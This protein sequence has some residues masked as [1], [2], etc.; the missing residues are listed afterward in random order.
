MKKG[1][2]SLQALSVWR[3]QEDSNLRPPGS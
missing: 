1:P 3:T 2:A